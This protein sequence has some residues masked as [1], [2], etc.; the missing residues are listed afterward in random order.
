MY[1]WISGPRENLIVMNNKKS[2]IPDK[3]YKETARKR[4]VVNINTLGRKYAMIFNFF[5]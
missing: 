4:Q 2:R 5:L 1:I 3:F